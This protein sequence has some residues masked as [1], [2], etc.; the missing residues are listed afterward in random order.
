MT[1]YVMTTAAVYVLGPWSHLREAKLR[2]DRFRL[3]TRD[4]DE[5]AEAIRWEDSSRR[6]RVRR[7]RRK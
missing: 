1:Q 3:R 7:M 6:S 2:A 5:L 4:E